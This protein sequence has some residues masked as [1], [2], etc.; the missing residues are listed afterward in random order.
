MNDKVETARTLRKNSTEAEK[1]L[2][3]RIR[4][5]ALENYKFRRQHPIAPYIADFFC[6]QR[7][8]IVEVD[9]GQHTPEADKDRSLFLEKAGFKILRF[10][11]NEVLE[12]IDGVLL[13]ILEVLKTPHSNPLPEGEGIKRIALGKIVAAHGIKGLVKILPYS[14]NRDLFNGAIYTSEQDFQTLTIKSK[15][16]LGKYLLAEVS[17]VTERNGAEALRHTELFIDKDALPEIEDGGGFYHADLVGLKAIDEHGTEIGAVISVENYGAGDLLE[18]RP[19]N[20]K[21]FLI[22][23][24]EDNIPEIDVASGSLQIRNAAMFM[25]LA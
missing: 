12:N 13:K 10:W 14:N 16:S 25:D 17:G 1:L 24:T 20:G 6:V 7:K 4:N 23:F 8:L 3:S 2:W 5:G 19:K 21:D 18:I 9:G 11:N 22:P 15:N